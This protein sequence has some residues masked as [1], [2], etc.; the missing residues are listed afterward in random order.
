MTCKDCLHYGVCWKQ[1]ELLLDREWDEEQECCVDASRYIELPCKVGD[2]VYV[3]GD[4][5]EKFGFY[6]I[7]YDH[8]FIHSRHFVFGEIVSI[9][10][11]KKQ[12]LIKIR[13]SSSNHSIYRH[14]RFPA[15]AFGKTVF[16]TREQAEKA[17][18]ERSSNDTT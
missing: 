16:L 6:F 5:W 8:C 13:V 18:A 15:S 12:L 1:H 10:K 11:T 2:R 17:L 4:C 3:D 9:I 14:K 7:F